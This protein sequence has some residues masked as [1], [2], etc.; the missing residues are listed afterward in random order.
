MSDIA[1]KLAL[2]VCQQCPRKDNESEL[3]YSTRLYSVYSS[4][5][6]NV[7][8]LEEQE[9][10]KRYNRSYESHLESSL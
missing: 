6:D 7:S 2:L 1:E 8:G 9:N 3:D 5:H 10:N 4:C